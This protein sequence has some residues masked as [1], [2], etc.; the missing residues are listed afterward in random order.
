MACI[1]IYALELIIY[2]PRRE[3]GRNNFYWSKTGEEP[4]TRKE[5]RSAKIQVSKDWRGES[6]SDA[7]TA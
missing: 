7:I 6:F 1:L 2:L 5:N 4:V 3:T